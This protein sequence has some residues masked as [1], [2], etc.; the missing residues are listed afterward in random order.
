MVEM[1]ELTWALMTF[2]RNSLKDFV[3]RSRDVGDATTYLL[4]EL[5]LE[6]ARVTHFKT[7]DLTTFQ[8]KRGFHYQPNQLSQ[9]GDQQRREPLGS[10]TS[11]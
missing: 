4:A 11:K 2:G 1:E 7:E 8:R 10:R 3:A 6:L 5:N 9:H